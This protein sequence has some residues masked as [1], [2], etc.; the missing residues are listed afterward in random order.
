LIGQREAE[1]VFYQLTK[2]DVKSPGS[3]RRTM[4]PWCL[5]SAQG[6]A[7]SSS[8]IRGSPCVHCCRDSHILGALLSKVGKLPVP[9]WHFAASKAQFLYT[10]F[11]LTYHSLT[12]FSL[13][14][15]LITICTRGSTIFCTCINHRPNFP[16]RK[17][18]RAPHI[19]P[20]T[21]VSWRD[22]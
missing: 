5:F 19:R 22:S 11:T 8:A 2:I 4:H 13:I 20:F 14:S 1:K 17:H 15:H 9:L 10:P 18:L 6:D 12:A 21:L 7:Q 3:I 16:K